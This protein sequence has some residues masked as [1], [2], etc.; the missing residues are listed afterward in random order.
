MSSAGVVVALSGTS[1]AALALLLLRLLLRH[2]FVVIRVSGRSMLSALRPG[3]RL[4]V[5]RDVITRLAVGMI[6]VA[7]AQQATRPDG[8]PLDRHWV[9]K[10]VA[11]LPGDPV[12]GSVRAAA[13]GISV[14]PDGQLV[15]LSD[16]P[17]GNDSRRWGLVPASDL[18]GFVVARLRA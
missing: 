11:A 8:A 10:R 9:I 4:L 3:D 1:A 16:N 13:G 18:I 12:P 15:L 2:R 6:V 14:V 5:R 17:A 7:R